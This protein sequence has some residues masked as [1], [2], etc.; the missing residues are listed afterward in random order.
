MDVGRDR[1]SG[2]RI[3]TDPSKPIHPV[4]KCGYPGSLIVQ[5]FNGDGVP[6][7]AVT[8]PAQ[9]EIKI[10]LSRCAPPT[11]TLAAEVIQTTVTL[12]AGELPAPWRRPT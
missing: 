5:D 11:G 10:A 8:L 6:D 1:P 7:I 3:F 12:P 9:N 4:L 2:S